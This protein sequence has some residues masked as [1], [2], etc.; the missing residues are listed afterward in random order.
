MKEREGLHPRKEQPIGVFDSGLGG[1]TV[2]REIMKQLPQEDIVYYGDLAR[3]PYG[4]KSRGQIRRFSC[5][6]AEFLLG[7]SVK[8]LVVACHSSASVSMPILRRRYPLTVVDVIESAAQKA[9][10]FSLAKRI[11]VIGTEATI[12]SRSYE[13]VLKKLDPHVKVFAQSCPLFVPL[14]EEGWL[15]SKVTRDVIRQ[16]LKSLLARK[17]DTLIL[18]CTHYPLLREAIQDFMGPRVVLVDSAGP[19]VYHLQET[20]RT[21]HLLSEHSNRGKLRVF[22]SDMPRNFIAVG[23][24]FLGCRLKHVRVVPIQSLLKLT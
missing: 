12:R 6:N 2:V 11:G 19:T 5:E 23:Q 18:G 20:L 15:R 4:I 16:Y 7:H 21:F 1:L 13:R 9:V 8:A 24:Q 17:I 10:R 14:V 3:L 22:V